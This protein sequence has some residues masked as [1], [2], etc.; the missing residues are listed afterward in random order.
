MQDIVHKHFLPTFFNIMGLNIYSHAKS[1]ISLLSRIKSY[2]GL[3]KLH[4]L[5][6]IIKEADEHL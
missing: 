6:I 2:D 5:Y 1:N 4:A 3:T